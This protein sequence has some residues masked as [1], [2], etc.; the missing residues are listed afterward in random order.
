MDVP[1]CPLGSLLAGIKS[2]SGGLHFCEERSG[3]S[4]G[5]KFYNNIPGPRKTLQDRALYYFRGNVGMY[6]EHNLPARGV[7]DGDRGVG[8]SA[9]RDFLGDRQTS[10]RVD[11]YGASPDSEDTQCETADRDGSDGE[12]PTGE[13]QTGS[14]R[15]ERQD[16]G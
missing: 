7:A 16:T 4:Y 9:C 5:K 3:Y 2:D 6:V 11:A 14:E 10:D 15:T 1:A 13:K 8:S 12:S